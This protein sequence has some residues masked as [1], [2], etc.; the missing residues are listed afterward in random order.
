MG[1]STRTRKSPAAELAVTHR[2]V[3]AFRLERLGLTRLA[4]GVGAAVGE[5]GL[6]DFPPGAALAAL[7][8]RLTGASPSTLVDAFDKRALVRLRAMRGAPVVV[9]MDD[10]ELFAAGVLPPDEPAMRAFIGPAI[11]SVLQARMTALDAVSLVTERASAAL[12]DGPLDRDQLH[13]ELRRTTPSGLLPY[14]R[15]CDSHHVHPS[16]VYAVALQGRLVVLP[17]DDGPYLVARFDRWSK[18]KPRRG[19]SVDPAAELLRRFLRVYGPATPALFGAWAGIGAA[20]VRATWAHLADD[21]VPV[22]LDDPA[23]RASAFIHRADV[24]AL[25][26][27]DDEETI[28]LISPGDP[29]LQM[30]DRST[31]VADP[32][33]QKVVWKNLA[34]TGLV[35]AGAR[36]VGLA[37]PRKKGSTLVVAVEQIDRIAARRRAAVADEAARLAAVRGCDDVEVTWS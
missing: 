19:R 35:L 12:S 32:A 15:G 11:K 27:A 18:V 30:R 25:A 34:P 1:A 16:L 31:L 29:L 21:L 26:G 37:R 33:R 17:R 36:V 9:R 8:P 6:C 3:I 10:F 14:C 28:R 4:R 24:S 7:A 23:H 20:Q 5:I 22:A 2:H 13:A